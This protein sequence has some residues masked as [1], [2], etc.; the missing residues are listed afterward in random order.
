MRRVFR[1]NALSLLMAGCATAVMSWL[2]LYGIGWNDY[3]LEAERSVQAL[4]HGHVSEFLRLAP[5]YGGSLIERAPFALLPGLWGGGRFAVYHALAVPC[6]A[7][8]ALLGVWLVARMRA[9]G[10]STRLSRALVLAL[11]AVNPLTLR[12][13]EIGHPEEILGGVLCVAAVLLAARG[14]ALWAG[15]VLGFAIANKQWALVAVGPVLVALPPSSLGTRGTAAL[16]WRGALAAA[17]GYLVCLASAGAVAAIVLAPLVLTSAGGVSGV[18]AAATGTIFEPWQV[19]WFFGHHGAPVRSISVIPGIPGAIKVGY[20]TA[21]AWVSTVSHPSV[22]AASAL[23][24]LLLFWV[25]RRAFARRAEAPAAQRAAVPHRL[26]DALLL[27]A[28]VLLARC[29]LDAWDVVYCALPCV[30]ALVAWES[31]IEPRRPAVLAL[32]T[33]LLVWASFEWTPGFLG[34]D[35]QAAFFLAWTLPL[36]AA[37]ALRLYAPALAASLVESLRGR[38]SQRAL[39]W[40]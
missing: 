1:E 27:L 9:S 23:L 29:L 2:A 25:R 7:A 3:Y 13:L 20:R 40:R 34:A 11:C 19:W 39:A 4:V 6:I 28:L 8:G 17:R 33:T 36:A 18:S 15:I 38:R 31:E 26:S 5:A 22:L 21:P 32:V 10:R 37:L 30:F 16:S 35:G 14:R 24:T 12:A